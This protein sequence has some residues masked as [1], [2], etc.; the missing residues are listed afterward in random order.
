M[1]GKKRWEMGATISKS[2]GEHRDGKS[3]VAGRVRTETS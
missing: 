3:F 2:A 1:T